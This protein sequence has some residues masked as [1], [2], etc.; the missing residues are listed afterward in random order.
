MTTEPENTIGKELERV[1]KKRSRPDFSAIIG[2][3]PN[4]L[5]LYERGERLP[6]IDFLAVFADRTGADFNKLLRLR[7]ASSKTEEARARED[8]GSS[9]A[10]PGFPGKGV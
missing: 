2:V 4:T 10:K 3:H 7:L 1:R 9:R 8:P 5:A 6:E